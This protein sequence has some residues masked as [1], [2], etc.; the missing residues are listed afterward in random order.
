[1][2]DLLLLALKGLA[3]GLLVT[4][5]AV[6]SEAVQ[7]KRFAGLFG[8]SPAVAIA[9]LTLVLVDQG[10]PAAHRS[11]IGMIAGTAGLIVYTAVVVPLL[12]RWNAGAAAA[13]ALTAWAAGAAVVAIPL[14]SLT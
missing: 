11:T 8:A 9:G 4:M 12:R 14:L 6:L 13:V 1:M 7:P 3:G 5:F 10:T 2:N